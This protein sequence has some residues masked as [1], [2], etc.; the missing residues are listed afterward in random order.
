MDD[1]AKIAKRIGG[2]SM[3]LSI[4]SISLTWLLIGLLITVLTSRPPETGHLNKDDENYYR[5]IF[6]VVLWPVALAIRVIKFIIWFSIVLY[7]GFKEEIKH[8]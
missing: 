7:M 2:Y 8:K 5:F 1:S 4:I 6:S 3:I